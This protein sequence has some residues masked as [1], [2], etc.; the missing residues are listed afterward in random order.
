M[1]TKNL[2]WALAAEHPDTATSIRNYGGLLKQ[3]GR[4]AEAEKLEARVKGNRAP[5]T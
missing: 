5:D 1:A 3:L 4:R 2:A